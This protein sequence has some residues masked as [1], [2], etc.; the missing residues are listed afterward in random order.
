M[1][2]SLLIFLFLF[3]WSLIANFSSCIVFILYILAFTTLLT[4]ALSEMQIVK[5]YAI[6]QTVFHENTS[7]FSI[8]KSVWLTLLLSLF[9]GFMASVIILVASIYLDAIIF[10]ILGFDVQIGRASCRERV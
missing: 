4:I 8:V 2:K 10:L 6:A 7:L 3:T 5:K 1:F 9:V